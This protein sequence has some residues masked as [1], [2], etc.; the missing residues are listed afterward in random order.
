MSDHAAVS[1]QVLE[2]AWNQ[3]DT[4][5]AVKLLSPNFRLNDPLSNQFPP[6]VEG[7]KTF[8]E[9]FRNALPDVHC[10]IKRQEVDG[11]TVKT[12]VVFTGTQTGQ[13]MN[14]PATG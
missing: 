12:S 5:Q 4:A 1:R 11:D 6:G 8:I 10:E 7:F 9:A 13:L 3:K 2:L 14:I